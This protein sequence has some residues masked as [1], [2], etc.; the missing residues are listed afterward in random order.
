MS[1]QERET[2][3]RV[4]VCD[5]CG[6]RIGGRDQLSLHATDPKAAVPNRTAY[7][8]LRTRTSVP[9]GANRQWRWDFHG[10]CLVK[11]LMPLVTDESRPESSKEG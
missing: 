6:E 3:E 2:V 4:T 10:E 5:L 8:L 7:R 11:A 1:N 9:Y